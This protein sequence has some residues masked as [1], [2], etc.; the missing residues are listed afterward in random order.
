MKKFTLYSTSNSTGDDYYS[1]FCF[2]PEVKT[3]VYNWFIKQTANTLRQKMYLESLGK[4]IKYQKCSG[5]IMN[6]IE[7]SEDE[8]G[9]IK[10]S[11]GATV[12][13][14]LSF[15]QWKTR[16]AKMNGRMATIWEH[17]I[18]VAYIM[19]S[20][21]IPMEIFT[22]DSSELGNYVNAPNG[23]L[24]KAG[25]YCIGQYHYGVGNTIKLVVLPSQENKV[26]ANIGA[27]YLDKGNYL[28][29]CNVCY[30]FDFYKK[31]KDSV[32]LFVHE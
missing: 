6:L 7:P 12:L 5:Q 29:V 23:K 9:M 8:N 27:C 4:A 17:D 32:A 3:K 13:T 25:T 22:D 31:Y 14:N 16:F 20:E 28:P 30:G 19:A 1:E 10:F 2:T 21:N 26:F 18:F 24:E 11:K 15:N